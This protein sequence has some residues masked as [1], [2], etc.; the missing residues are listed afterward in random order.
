MSTPLQ[1]L[2]LESHESSEEDDGAPI[3]EPVTMEEQLALRA[4]KRMRKAAEIH[5][6]AEVF[7]RMVSASF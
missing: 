6:K 3:L 2:I 7:R 5:G 1:K 4:E